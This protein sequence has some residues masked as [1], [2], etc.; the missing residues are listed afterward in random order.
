LELFA[1]VSGTQPFAADFL[2]R[3]L[4]PK[5]M[6]MLPLFTK[7]VDNKLPP[8]VQKKYRETLDLLKG[9]YLNGPGAGEGMRLLYVYYTAGSLINAGL[10]ILFMLLNLH[11]AFNVL[12]A[13][14][15]FC[16]ELILLFLH[17]RSFGNRIGIAARERVFLAVFLSSV[18]LAIAGVVIGAL[19]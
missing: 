17:N 5:N 8:N 7:Y 1:T 18:P 13:M 11:F 12:I 3:V 16:V 6:G 4:E 14:V 15:V 19:V 2:D 9:E 10:V